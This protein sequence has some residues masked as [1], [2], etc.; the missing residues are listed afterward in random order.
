MH[1]YGG[2]HSDRQYQWRASSPN[3]NARQS[4]PQYGKQILKI[5]QGF[6]LK[7]VNYRH[8]IQNIKLTLT[9]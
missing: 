8:W 9:P 2:K 7:I 3:F 4:Y 1:A 6:V 5:T